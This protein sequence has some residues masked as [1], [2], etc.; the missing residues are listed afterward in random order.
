MSGKDRPRN[1]LDAMAHRHYQQWLTGT[2]AV[3][4]ALD[5]TVLRIDDLF[6]FVSGALKRPSAAGTAFDYQVRGLTPGY[7]GDSNRVK[8]SV[9]PN[10]LAVCF[11]VAGG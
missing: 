8:F 3:E 2:A 7:A 10:G 6:V 4:Y 11:L 1:V 5:R 9:A